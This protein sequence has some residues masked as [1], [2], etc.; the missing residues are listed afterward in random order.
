[1]NAAIILGLILAAE[2]V[3]CCPQFHHSCDEINIAR[4]FG[5]SNVSSDSGSRQLLPPTYSVNHSSISA[6]Q[7][8]EFIGM[9]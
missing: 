9:S 1:M 2:A 3:Y 7:I 4:L 5:I 6:Q 8:S